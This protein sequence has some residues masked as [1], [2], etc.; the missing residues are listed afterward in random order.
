MTSVVYLASD[1]GGYN[2]KEELKPWLEEKGLTVEDLGAFDLNPQDD[3]PDFVLPLAQKV[4][5]NQNSKGIILGRSGNGEAIAANKVKSVRAVLCFNEKMAQMARE[6]NDANII[7]LGAD[8][9]E[10]EKMKLIVQ[11]FLETPFPG[12]ERHLRRLQKI[13]DFEENHG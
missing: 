12:E 3:Y 13:R 8:Y 11:V 10:P 4:A 6:H 5:S 7:S 1:H 9:L 2:L